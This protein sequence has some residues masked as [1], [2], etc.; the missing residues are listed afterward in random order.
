M[1]AT[2]IHS[3]QGENPPIIADRIGGSCRRLSVQRW[4]VSLALAAVASGMVATA[5][6]I[7]LNKPTSAGGYYANYVPSNVVDGDVNTFWNGGTWGSP[8]AGTWVKVD[9]EAAIALQ[10]VVLRPPP[11]GS[12]IY[13]VYASIDDA[14]WVQLATGLD[15]L[16]ASVFTMDAGGQTFRYIRC[17]VVGG[18]DWAAVAELEAYSVE[19]GELTLGVTEQPKSQWAS[20]GQDI[21]FNVALTNAAAPVGYQ[22]LKDSEPLPG[23]TGATLTLTSLRIADAGVY[24]VVVTDGWGRTITSAP[25]TLTVASAKTSIALY[26]GITIEGVVGLTYGIQVSADPANAGSWSGRT[27]ITLQTATFLWMD[28]EPASQPQRYYRVVP[29]PISIP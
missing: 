20:L 6:N 26:P 10:A 22:W 24:K 13:E 19:G 7:A 23:A 4:W 28:S 5:A 12:D 17:D 16:K 2:C 27:N 8:S 25:A 9:L 15:S 29:G 3:S 1:R 21:T 18:G 14:N 11:V